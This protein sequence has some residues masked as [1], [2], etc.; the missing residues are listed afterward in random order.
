MR[1]MGLDYGS[2]T[3]GVSVTDGLGLTVQPLETLTRKRENVLRQTYVRLEALCRELEIGLL[4]VGL[5]LNMNDSEGER[6]QLARAFGDTLAR[7]TG[8]PVAYQDERLTTV[9]A[10]E[11]LEETGLAREKRKTVIDRLAACLILEDYL[12]S[13][14]KHNG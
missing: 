11:L 7:R 5:P 1:I 13:Q 12:H 10:D 6:A 3:V 14:E 4:V 9:E 8:L 2:K